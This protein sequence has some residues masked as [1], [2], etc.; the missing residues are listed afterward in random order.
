MNASPLPVL[1]YILHSG[2]LFGT[3]RMAMATVQGLQDDFDCRLLAP[4]GAAVELARAQ[5]LQADAF[6]GPL[7]LARIL[8]GCFLGHRQVT[9]IATGISQ[10][11]LAIVLAGLTL[12]RL[13]HIHIVHGGTDERLSYG[14]KKILARFAVHYLAVSDFVRQRLIAHAVPAA[15]ITVIENFLADAPASVRTASA[16]TVQTVSAQHATLI[17]N[18]QT[19]APAP[20]HAA[21]AAPVQQVLLVS[22][23]DPIKRVDVLLDALEIC[24]ELHDLN[25]DIL[26]TGWDATALQTRASNSR[27]PVRFGGFCADV[28][29]AL[30]VADLLVH[31][32][33][34]EPFGLVILEA[35]TA[36][37]PVLVP[38]TGGPA[39]FI[40]DGDNGFVF[41]ANDAQDLA[42]K[43]LAIRALT[44]QQ[45]QA[46]RRAATATLQQ[47]FAASDRIND[48]RLLLTGELT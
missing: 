37:V 31:T 45:L 42:R 13:R 3:E 35:M 14:R 29:A 26:G 46:I 48:Y 40:R 47:R 28:P 11:L 5:G 12:T 30:A 23:L 27:L 44:S 18:L 19:D 7:S 10:S 36:G 32:C 22:R 39:G 16:R 43:L 9:L 24:P 6:L 41:R 34:E 2:N 25:I 8:L 21:P 17:K 20:V 38:D 1:L 15:R 33:P 4:P